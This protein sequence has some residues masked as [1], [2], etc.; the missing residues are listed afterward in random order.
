MKKISIV[1]VVVFLATTAAYGGTISTIG[2]IAGTQ[3][4]IIGVTGFTT[5][6]SD[7]AGLSVSVMFATSGLRNCI[8][9][10][11]SA[12][13]G[14]C[15]V[16]G[17]FSI[18]QDGDTFD[19]TNPWILRNLTTFDSIN[20]LTLD[21]SPGR[22]SDEGTV[23]D[24]TFGDVVGTLG[25]AL[26]KDADGSTSDLSNGSALYQNLVAISPGMPVGDI[27]TTLTIRFDGNG[28][29]AG[30]SASFV[31]DTDTIGVLSVPEP[32]TF[33]LLTIG[34]VG[35]ILRHRFAPSH[36]GLRR[37]M[38]RGDALALDD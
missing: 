18:T 1:C 5:L 38:I 15:G 4:N 7:M 6:G 30:Q 34:L 27:F 2:Q 13:A 33:T 9:M 31:A 19:D 24:R 29:G 17:F 26:G 23:F 37:R 16:P 12:T 11:Q 36:A 25:S 28:L 3:L 22:L 14:G 10:V 20:L 32:A 8:W 21:G 35:V